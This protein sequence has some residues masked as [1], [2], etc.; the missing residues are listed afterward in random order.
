MQ[1]RT[2]VGSQQTVDER[3]RLL[4]QQGQLILCPGQRWRAQWPLVY[5]KKASSSAPRGSL[6]ALSRSRHCWACCGQV[7]AGPGCR[8]SAQLA[9]LSES[10]GRPGAVWAL[11]EDLWETWEN[12]LTWRGVCT[13]QG[14]HPVPPTSGTGSSSHSVHK[15]RCPQLGAGWVDRGLQDLPPGITYF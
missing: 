8:V 1:S 5:K 10:P 3:S 15:H 6:S 4:A 7:H 13:G 11:V 12:R 9:L 2:T 14:P